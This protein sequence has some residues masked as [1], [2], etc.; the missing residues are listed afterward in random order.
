[1]KIN[2][3]YS[4]YY[5]ERSKS[6]FINT[7]VYEF[8]HGIQMSMKTQLFTLGPVIQEEYKNSVRILQFK[9]ELTIKNCYHSNETKSMVTKIQLVTIANKHKKIHGYQVTICYYSKQ[10]QKTWLPSYNLLL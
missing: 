1:M 9:I 3:T 10:T 6:H 4:I 7:L 8:I 5:Y 2:F